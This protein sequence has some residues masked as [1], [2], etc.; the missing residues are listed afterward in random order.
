MKSQ[1][2][3]FLQGLVLGAGSVA[4]FHSKILGTGNGAS[5]RTATKP[6]YPKVALV[7]GNDRRGNLSKALEIVG[8]DFERRVGSKQ[9]VIKPN[10]TRVK[11]EDWLASTHVDSLWA[12]CEALETFYDKTIIIA[13]GT[14]PGTPLQEALDNYNYLPLEERFN[15]EF[16]DLGQ[17]DHETYYFLDQ[18]FRP[19][20]VELSRLLTRQDVFLISAAIL[21]THSLSVA[22]LGLKNLI[23][24]TP[25]NFG[26][27][28]N[29][30]AK[31]HRDRVP[32]NPRPFNWNLFQ[33]SRVVTPDLVTIDGF[34]GMEGNGPL[35][36]DPVESKIALAGLDWLATDRV[37]IEVMGLDFR[38]I[39][40]YQYCANAGMG[41]ADLSK[42]E[43]VGASIGSC[44]R[45]Y[46][47]PDTYQGITM[48]V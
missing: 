2:R 16:V 30:R 17:D 35:Y 19:V 39:A 11:K 44:R 20:T 41:E 48:S 6:P 45:N 32:D 9:V 28:H 42:I 18:D 13:E 12:L 8:P 7:K 1:R 25:M 24:A 27:G 22:T 15:V 3:R 31:I 33:L 29:D 23:M 37:G 4:G 46:K 21:K 5:N 14:G 40:H 36:G 47:V 10:L 38:K 34:V 43:V 26:A